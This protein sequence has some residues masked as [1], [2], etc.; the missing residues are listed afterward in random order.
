MAFCGN[1]EI[2]RSQSCKR[3]EYISL[4]VL[5]QYYICISAAMGEC[6]Q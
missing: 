3:I 1:T 2:F 4:E 6:L 5:Q